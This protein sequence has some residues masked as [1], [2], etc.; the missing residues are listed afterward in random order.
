M[1]ELGGREFVLRPAVLCFARHLSKIGNTGGL[2]AAR[3]SRP[4]V[5]AA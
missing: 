5:V 4:N 3:I 1:S 2:A